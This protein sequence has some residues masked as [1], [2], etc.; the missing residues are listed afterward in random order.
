MEKPSFLSMTPKTKKINFIK[1]SN[2]LDKR[3]TLNEIED[4]W[5]VGEYICNTYDKQYHPQTQSVSTNH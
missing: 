5:E 2:N 4:K 3:H 1:M